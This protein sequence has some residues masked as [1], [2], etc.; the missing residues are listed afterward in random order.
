MQTILYILFLF[1]SSRFTQGF[2]DFNEYQKIHISKMM[3][4]SF[5]LPYNQKVDFITSC[6]YLKGF[7]S[8]KRKLISCW[9]L[10]V[11]C[12]TTIN[13]PLKTIV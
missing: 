4:I 8:M 1:S 5:I 9:R 2:I 11:S 3:L 10:C 7:I 12:F 6:I 13:E